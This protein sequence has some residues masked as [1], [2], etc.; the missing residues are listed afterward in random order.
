M[1]LAVK[2]TQTDKVYLYGDVRLIGKA[3]CSAPSTVI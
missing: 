1:S 3:K 2:D